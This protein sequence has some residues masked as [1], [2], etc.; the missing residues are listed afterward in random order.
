MNR[1]NKCHV[2]T[3]QVLKISVTKQKAF[4]QNFQQ[5]ILTNN[6][7]QSHIILLIYFQEEYIHVLHGKCKILPVSNK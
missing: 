2:V 1:D 6:K 7:E 5:W 3:T 4:T